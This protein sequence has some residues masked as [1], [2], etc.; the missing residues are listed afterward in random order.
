MKK[1]F[2]ALLLFCF[3][4]YGLAIGLSLVSICNDIYL[5][6]HILVW[7]CVLIFLALGYTF[8]KCLI[9]DIKDSKR[10]YKQ[11]YTCRAR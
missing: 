2:I 6:A 1:E 10:K 8:T 3:C 4:C 5:G 9:H 11:G 7:A